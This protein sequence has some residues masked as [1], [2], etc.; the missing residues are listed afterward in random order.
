MAVAAVMVATSALV[1]ARTLRSRAEDGPQRILPPVVLLMVALIA[2]YAV[3]LVPLGFLPTSL[4][5]LT[6]ATALLRRGR[7][8]SSFVVSL[9]TLA[10]V[11]VVFRLVFTVLMPPG[12]VPEGEI[13]ARLG[14]L[15][16][17]GP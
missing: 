4:A 15:L 1:L 9:A 10:G 16:S 11:W 6:A 5:F 2:A 7:V 14:A 17:G 8:A 3:L 13:L 12:V